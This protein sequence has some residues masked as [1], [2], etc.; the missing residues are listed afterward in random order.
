[1]E[2]LPAF[3]RIANVEE[4]AAPIAADAARMERRARRPGT[5]DA[6]S[7][8]ARA[9]W[10]WRPVA[11]EELIVVSG[12]VASA[13]GKRPYCGTVIARA[14]ITIKSIDGGHLA[15]EVAEFGESRHASACKVSTTE[16]PTFVREITY[17]VGL[18]QLGPM[19][20]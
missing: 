2:K 11:N 7:F 9:A 17:V 12:C 1:M 20:R 19:K 3:Q 8:V 4:A 13:D 15:P 10:K 18:I 14:G 6:K 5:V 16:A